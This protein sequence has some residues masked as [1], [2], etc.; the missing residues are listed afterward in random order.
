[1]RPTHSK[2]RS[3]GIVII[4]ATTRLLELSLAA[5]QVYPQRATL[6]AHTA[7]L[8]MLHIAPSCICSGRPAE[9]DCHYWPAGWSGGACCLSTCPAS[10]R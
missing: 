7:P 5:S 9:L 6:A 10:L 4:R 2:A 8:A 1:M 3:R